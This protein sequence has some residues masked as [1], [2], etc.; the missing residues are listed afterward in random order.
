MELSMIFSDPFVR[1]IVLRAATVGVLVALCGGLLGVTL[2]LKRYSMIGDGLSHV[3]FG[4]MALAPLLALLPGAAF[5]ADYALEIS[6][7]VV[8]A[9]AFFLLRLSENSRLG[10]DSAIAL[11]ST[12]SMAV[13]AILYQVTTGMSS[14]IC[15]NLFSSASVLNITNKDLLLSV[16]LCSA[17]L[18]LFVLCY[19]RLFSVTFDENF[20]K[21]TG[22]HPAVFK[23]LLALLTSVTVVLGIRMMGAVLVSA[24]I[25]FPAL[26]A[27][28]L[29]K[30]F[31]AVI[32]CAACISVVCFLI[33]FTIACLCSVQTGPTV[34]LVN[35]AVFLLS[36]AF[37]R[38]KSR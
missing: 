18:L 32:L 7:P 25:I 3:G 20:C 14:D 11:I 16:I 13:G 9:A 2:V 29:F 19:H 4:A 5:L 15:S 36:T 26:T 31:R 23:L 1:G 34:V 6:I 27:M 28:R 35:L 17:V 12:A 33:G 37:A 22:G 30:S 21:A 8:G 24:V 38:V 10:G